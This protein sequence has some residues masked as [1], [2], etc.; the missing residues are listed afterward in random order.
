MNKRY[1]IAILALPA[2]FSAPDG[3]SAQGWIVYRPASQCSQI[4]VPRGRTAFV[5]TLRFQKSGI[6]QMR[7]QWEY[8]CKGTS[9]AGGAYLAVYQ[10]NWAQIS[11]ECYGT[12]MRSC[13]GN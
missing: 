2:F 10:N 9:P 4:R 3:A 6:P 8:E 12:P 11:V 1:L 5:R 7:G 13:T